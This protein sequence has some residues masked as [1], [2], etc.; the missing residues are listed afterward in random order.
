[1]VRLMPPPLPPSSRALRSS[2]PSPAPRAALREDGGVEAA[3]SSFRCF[4]LFLLTDA[5]NSS[6]EMMPPASPSIEQTRAR[7]R[8]HHHHHH[9]LL[10]THGPR[11]NSPPLGAAPPIDSFFLLVFPPFGFG[12]FAADIFPQIAKVQQKVLDAFGL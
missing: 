1:M 9:H 12:T 6:K 10:R 2:Q 11:K 7:R 3:L 8:R 5:I 4:E